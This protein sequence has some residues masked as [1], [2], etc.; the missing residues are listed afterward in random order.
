MVMS[1]GTPKGMKK[2]L[3][4]RGVDVSRMKAKD[5]RMRLREMQDFKYEKTKVETFISSRGHHCIFNP[6]YHCELNPIER[7]WGYAKKYTREHCDYTFAGLERT[8]G[9]ALDSISTDLIRK[10]FRKKGESGE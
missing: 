5:M 8:A 10:Y 9:P 6:K 3:E 1:D 2:V 7:V 4:E